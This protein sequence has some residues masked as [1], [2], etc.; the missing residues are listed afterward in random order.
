MAI[1]ISDALDLIYQKI[2]S[3]G[4]ETIPMEESVGRVVASDYSA[5]CNLPRFNNSAMDGYAVRLNDNNKSVHC[6]DTIYAGDKAENILRDG[7]C[8]SIMTGAPIPN[9][10][11]AIVPKDSIEYMKKKWK[12]WFKRF[13]GE[14]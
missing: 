9:G 10:C 11:E 7:R 4:V 12:E 3:V 1:S 8:I 5:S 13:Q 14:F 2:N 6:I